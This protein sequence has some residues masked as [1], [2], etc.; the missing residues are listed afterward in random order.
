MGNLNSYSTITPFTA[1]RTVLKCTN[2][3]L[4][5]PRNSRAFSQNGILGYDLRATPHTCVRPR[6]QRPSEPGL[7]VEIALR[8]GQ[9]LSLLEHRHSESLPL[10]P[11]TLLGVRQMWD[12]TV[13]PCVARY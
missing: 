9:S 6:S 5:N 8:M 1:E 2:H 12:R 13:D 4:F 10:I 3:L 11:R 7:R